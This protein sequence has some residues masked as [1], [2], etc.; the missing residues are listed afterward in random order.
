MPNISCKIILDDVS[1]VIHSIFLAIITRTGFF[2]AIPRS[3]F[4]LAKILVEIQQ[5]RKFIADATVCLTSVQNIQKK[6]KHEFFTY[7]T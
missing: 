7:E 4:R 6:F 1:Q 2:T 3:D 5:I